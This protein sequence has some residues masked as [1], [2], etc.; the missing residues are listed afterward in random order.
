MY[1][2]VI[3]LSPHK[4]IPYNKQISS[5]M[6]IRSILNIWEYLIENNKARHY[7]EQAY[8]DALQQTKDHRQLRQTDSSLSKLISMPSKL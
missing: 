2:F 3:I 5:R 4:I 8:N 7:N 6:R 1:L